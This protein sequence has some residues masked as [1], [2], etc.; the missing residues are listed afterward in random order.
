MTG[1]IHPLKIF[2]IPSVETGSGA[3]V[4]GRER[5]GRSG[6]ESGPQQTFVLER[7]LNICSDLLSMT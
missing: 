5:N 2:T 1:L 3:G 7:L 6:V 4:S